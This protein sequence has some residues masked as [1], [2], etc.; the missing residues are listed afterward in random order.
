MVGNMKGVA[1]YLKELGVDVTK[2]VNHYPAVCG[3]SVDTM[4]RTVAYLEE[5]GVDVVNVVNRRPA[6]FANS[7]ENDC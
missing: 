3:Y 4:M 7:V 2:V 5:L 6:V 1:A